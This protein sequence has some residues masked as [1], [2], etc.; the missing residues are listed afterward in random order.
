MINYKKLHVE[1]E[2]EYSVVEEFGSDIE[3]IERAVSCYIENGGKLE[4]FN[5]YKTYYKLI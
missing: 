5:Y 3:S 1:Y 2:D 4:N